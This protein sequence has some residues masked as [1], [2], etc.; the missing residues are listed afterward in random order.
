MNLEIKQL[1][2]GREREAMALR[3]WPSTKEGESLWKGDNERSERGG[4]D[5][6]DEAGGGSNNSYRLEKSA[7]M[8]RMSPLAIPWQR[9]WLLGELPR[10]NI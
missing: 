9:Q 6:G 2:W 1:P 7:T 5:G 4:G 10:R 3:R 8:G